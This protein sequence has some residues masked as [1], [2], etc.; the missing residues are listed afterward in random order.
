MYGLETA[1]TYLKQRPCTDWFE[2]EVPIQMGIFELGS[3]LFVFTFKTIF[4]QNGND[5]LAFL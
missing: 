3:A 4:I 5:S 1:Q 2:L